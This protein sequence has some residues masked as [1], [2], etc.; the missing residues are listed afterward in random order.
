MEPLPEDLAQACRA[1]QL[2]DAERMRLVHEALERLGQEDRKI[3]WMTLVQ[4][5]KPGE[6]AAALGLTSE[7]VRTRKTRAVKKVA[8]LIRKKLSRT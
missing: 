5:S 7:V 6:I 4:G 1:E 2:E 3:V 8:D